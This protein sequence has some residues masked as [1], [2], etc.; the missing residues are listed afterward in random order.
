MTSGWKSNTEGAS[1]LSL[2]AADSKSLTH[3]WSSSRAQKDSNPP[4][5]RICLCQQSSRV[6]STLSLFFLIG[7][8]KEKK[9]DSVLYK[10]MSS[11]QEIDLNFHRET[12]RKNSLSLKV[13]DML[14]LVKRL[15][16]S[17]LLTSKEP[18]HV[19]LESNK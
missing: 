10:C 17:R 11:L 3:L 14:F 4:L 7:K 8:K 6:L 15:F 9:K 19:P 2:R 13:C 18:N 5:S 12:H 1:D 16:A